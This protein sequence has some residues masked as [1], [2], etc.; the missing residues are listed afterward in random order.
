M[1][2]FTIYVYLKDDRIRLWN[3]INPVWNITIW[4]QYQIVIMY[5]QWT[6]MVNGT[7][8]NNSYKL[9]SVSPNNNI[10][11]VVRTYC[12]L[13]FIENWIILKNNN[14]KRRILWKMVKL[15]FIYVRCIN[16]L[17]DRQNQLFLFYLILNK[18]ITNVQCHALT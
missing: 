10:A 2:K 17:F 11:F 1:Y 13:M 4:F 15:F 6:H 7:F 3:K 9:S 18:T 12:T 16:L 8:N 5:E 14:S